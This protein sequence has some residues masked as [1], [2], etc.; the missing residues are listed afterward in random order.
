[1]TETVIEPAGPDELPQIVEMFNQIFR[2][3]RTVESFR[4]R[5]LGRQNILQLIAKYRDQPAGF[6]LGFE[7]KP[8]TYFA[9]FYGVL[10]TIRRMGL[11]G[12]LM[13]AAQKWAAEKGYNS[14]RLECY[15]QQRPMLHLA[16]ELGY[17]IVGVRWDASRSSNLVIFEKVLK[18]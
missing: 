6:F 1:M 15:N 13:E 16:I 10:P 4:R 17:D 11:G 18:S 2:P 3:T 9:W 5:F 8:D 7:L 12:E 14:I